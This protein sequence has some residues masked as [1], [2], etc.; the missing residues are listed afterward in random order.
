MFEAHQNIGRGDVA[1]TV[2]REWLLKRNCALSP[3]Q[4]GVFYLTLVFVSLLIG[5]VFA[6]L[7]AWMVLPFSGLEM[8]ALGAALVIYGRHALDHERVVL[9]DCG[10]TVETVD[11]GRRTVTR[12]NPYW[13][14][15]VTESGFRSAVYLRDQGLRVAVGRHLDDAGRRRFAQ[16][17]RRALAP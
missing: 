12:L 5:S 15:V 11:A 14:Q 4:L 8:I 6:L 16:E 17:L 13:V 1:R 3:L 7:G 10:L 9:N 2:A